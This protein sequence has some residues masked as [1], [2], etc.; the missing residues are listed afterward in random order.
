MEGRILRFDIQPD[1]TLSAATTIPT[2]QKAN[3]GPRLVTGIC[4]D[5]ASTA[6][7]M[8]LWVSHGM[9]ALKEAVDWSGKISRLSGAELGECTDFVVGLPRGVRDHLNNQ[10]AFGPDGALYFCQASDT[11]M[12]APDSKWGFREEHLLSAAILRLDVAKLGRPGASLPLDVKT[13]DGG[14]YDPAAPGAPLTLYATGVRNAYDILWH[15]NGALYAPINGSAAGGNTPGSPPRA[16]A[17]NG[18]ACGPVPA[19]VDVRQTLDDYLFRVEPGAYY[20]HPNPKRGQFVLNGGNPTAGADP[21]EISS[22]PVGTRP[23]KHWKP[24]TFSFG[25]NLSPTGTLE[26]RNASAFN[27]LLRGKILVCR[28]SGGD[29]V[30]ILS[31]GASGGIIEAISGVD[32]LTRLMDPLDVAEDVATGNLYVSEFQ[33]RRLTLLRPRTGEGAVSA[34]VFRQ[35]VGT[36]ATTAPSPNARAN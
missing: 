1:G 23:E 28:Y 21:E 20:G 12:G 8:V 26:Y 34:R 6:D 25:K 22:Y 15:S 17:P 30:V 3:R 27:G 4:F 10:P 9:L 5:P 36:A 18:G 29:D 16:A 7:R 2:I 14:T 35:I 24:A 31:P 11:A 19:L 32:G 33:P 13:E